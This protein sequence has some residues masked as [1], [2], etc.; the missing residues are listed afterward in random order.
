MGSSGASELS[1]KVPKVGI[2]ADLGA[3]SAPLWGPFWSP[4]PRPTFPADAL[5]VV[6][7][8]HW[9]LS[10][11]SFSVP[12]LETVSGS[13]FF[14][15]WMRPWLLRLK[16][17]PQGGSPTP[18]AAAHGQGFREGKCRYKRGKLYTGRIRSDTPLPATQI[19]GF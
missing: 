15:V 7:G 2:V 5:L 12:G 9:P 10:G 14:D 16:G 19:G 3:K 13:G 6:L 17:G 8:R 18:P 1:Q 11:G 4:V